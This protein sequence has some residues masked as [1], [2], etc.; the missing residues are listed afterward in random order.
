MRLRDEGSR[1]EEVMT[2]A[3]TYV[4]ISQQSQIMR[5]DQNS[6]FLGWPLARTC[7]VIRSQSFSPVCEA[8]NTRREAR[9]AAALYSFVL[10]TMASYCGGCGTR[11]ITAGGDFLMRY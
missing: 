7:V 10:L 9:T 11:L 2:T 3:L 8:R 4:D 5:S 1:I 6:Y